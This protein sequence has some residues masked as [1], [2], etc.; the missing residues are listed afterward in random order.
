[1]LPAFFAQTEKLGTSGIELNMATTSKCTW[2][3]V[4][5]RFGIRC[6]RELIMFVPVKQKICHILY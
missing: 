3:E 6:L 2:K 1:M 5:L 4:E